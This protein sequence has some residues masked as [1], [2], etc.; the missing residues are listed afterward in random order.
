[1][2]GVAVVPPDLTPPVTSLDL[3]QYQPDLGFVVAVAKL[4][5]PVVVPQPAIGTDTLVHA[6]DAAAVA[7]SGYR[8]GRDRDGRASAGSELRVRFDRRAR[9][10][11][12]DTGDARQSGWV[13]NWVNGRD[14]HVA[15]KSAD[16]R[17]VLPRS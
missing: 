7:S 10:V 9:L 17:V 15:R 8:D 5:E 16:W 14:A 1:M 6:A 13:Q 2:S 11:D 12:A 3:A 4:S